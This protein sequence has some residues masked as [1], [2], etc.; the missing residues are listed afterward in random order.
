VWESVAGDAGWGGV[1]PQTITAGGGK[2][3]WIIHRADQRERMLELIDESL[4]LL[5]PPQRWQTTFS[6]YYTGLPPEFDCRICCVLAGT[7][8]AKL[9]ATRGSVLDL[10]Q[11]L[12][13]PPTGD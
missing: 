5:P 9:A 7:P 6:T 3:L 12:G 2:P 11:P 10:T 13:Q 1:I 4:S 8:E